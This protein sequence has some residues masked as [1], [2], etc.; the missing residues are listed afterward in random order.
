MSKSTEVVEDF[1][2]ADDQIRGQNFV[3]LSFV[4]PESVIKNK[5]LFKMQDFLRHLVKNN[6][7]NLSEDYINNLDEKYKDYLYTREE[8]LEKEFYE[9]NDFRTTIR[10]LKVRGVYDTVKEANMRAQKLQKKDKNF[11]VYVGQVGYWLPWDPEPHQVGEQEYF[12]SDLNQLVKKYKENQEAK[13][14]HF[15][16]NVEYVKEQ[17]AKEVEKK[18]AE[19]A[20]KVEEALKQTLE[21]DDPWIAAKKREDTINNTNT[22]ETV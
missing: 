10:G 6:N 14:T 8:T 9:N 13:E 3:C 1:L 11:N 2:E 5:D 15:R 12:E 20:N 7:I 17:A 16:E 21:G 22:N 19:S 4:S 18:K